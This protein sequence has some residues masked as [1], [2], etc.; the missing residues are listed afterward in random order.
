MRLLLIGCGGYATVYVRELLSPGNTR[1]HEIMGIVDPFAASSPVYGQIM[2]QGI[3]LY[4]TIEVF[5]RRHQ[6]PLAIISTPI[7]LH[8]HDALLCLSHGSHLL[9]EKPLATT[10]ALSREILMAARDAGRKLGVGYQLCYDPV[11]LALKKEIDAGELG[12]PLH[13][14]ALILWQRTRAY[15]ARS[16]GWAGKKLLSDGTPVY[17]S[18]LTNAAAHYLMNMLWLT[19]PGYETQSALDCEAQ[20]GRAYPIET[21]DTAAARFALPCGCDGLVFASHVAGHEQEQNPAMEYAFEKATVRITPIPGQ[22]TLVTVTDCQGKTRK[23]GTLSEGVSCKI[24]GMIRS[25]EEGAP[26][27]CPGDAALASVISNELLFRD[28]LSGVE[29]IRP[30]QADDEKIWVPGVGEKLRKAYTA[31]QL[32]REMGLM[33][34]PSHCAALGKQ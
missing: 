9:L 27:T 8:P 1:G 20:L 22:S 16:G 3:P 5:Y 10:A 30:I 24:E 31:R 12:R 18:I 28:N 23:L 14:S 2:A 32:P 25:L 29:T 11:M 4:D 33:Y 7:A 6:A 15:Y 19:T 21:F 13:L 34:S 17:D 26:L